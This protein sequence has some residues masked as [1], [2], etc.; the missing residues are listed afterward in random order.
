MSKHIKLWA[1]NVFNKWKLFRNF[2]TTKFITNMFKDEGLITDLWICYHLLFQKMMVAY[3]L[4]LGTIFHYFLNAFIIEVF[5][6]H[7][8]F[9]FLSC[10]CFYRL[11]VSFCY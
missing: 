2:D 5:F 7:V 8:F 11:C 4:Q 1:M 6:H 3:I 9:F 10:L